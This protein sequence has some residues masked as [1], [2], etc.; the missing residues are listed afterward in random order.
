MFLKV[1]TGCPSASARRTRAR[2]ALDG[3]IVDE[4]LE[5]FF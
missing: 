5:V 3:A 4:E 1:W 2:T